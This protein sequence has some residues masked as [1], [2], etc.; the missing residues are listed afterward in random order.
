VTLRGRVRVVLCSVYGGNE[1]SWMMRQ[2]QG[3][4]SHVSMSRACGEA[5]SV[6]L[7]PGST[8]I[9]VVPWH[10]Y[11]TKYFRVNHT[12]VI[13]SVGTYAVIQR[14]YCAGTG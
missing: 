10:Y 1:K 13:S 5:G 9:D 8:F 12:G 2:G 3:R 11:C 4:G 7:K 14:Y 6:L